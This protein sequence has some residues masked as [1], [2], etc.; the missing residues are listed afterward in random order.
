MVYANSACQQSHF[1]LWQFSQHSIVSRAW[2][3]I[4]VDIHWVVLKLTCLSIDNLPYTYPCTCART[5]YTH[6]HAHSHACMYAH[7]HTHIHTHAHAHDLVRGDCPLHCSTGETWGYCWA[8]AGSKC[9]PRPVEGNPHIPDT[10]QV[11]WPRPS[12]Y[13]SW[14]THDLT[15]FMISG[16]GLFHLIHHDRALT[17]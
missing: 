12:I 4:E 13:Q 7:T 8:T 6:M 16:C 11:T 5:P 1:M 2:T 17:W 15:L 3:I 9:W 10:S 14:S